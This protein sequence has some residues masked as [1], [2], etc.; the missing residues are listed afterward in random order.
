MFHHG[1]VQATVA[2]YSAKAENA[3]AIALLLTMAALPILEV[4]LRMAFGFGIPGVIAY[5]QNLALC[6][7]F[8]G[9][10][11]A[12]RHGRHLGLS[13]GLAGLRPP[14][15]KALVGSSAAITVA[16]TAGLF[17]ASVQFVSSEISSPE[18]IGGILPIWVVILVLPLSYGVVL[19]RTLTCGKEWRSWLAAFLGL[20]ICLAI[21]S[22]PD[23]LAALLTWPAIAVLIASVFIGA[24]IFVVLGGAALVLFMAE[25][26]PV[27][28]IP[29]ETYRI[30]TSPTIP[31]IP[32][33]T[34][35][36][37]LLAESRA[38][39][40]LVRLFRALFGWLP[41]GMAIVTTLICAFFA[42][43]TGTSGVTI[44]ALGG[45]LYPVLLE[46]GYRKRFSLGLLTSTGSIGLLFPPS[47]AIVLYG[48]VA[49]LPIPDLFLAGVVPGVL[50]VV[51][52]SLLAL[53]EGLRAERSRVRFDAME[54]CAAIWGAKWE[55]M[56]PL[57]VLVGIFGGFMTLVEAAALSAIYT[58]FVVT[59][60]YRDLDLYADLPRVF[61][62]CAML[63]GAVF[64]VL[65]VALGLTNYMVD[66]QIPVKAA[67]W[68]KH[69]IDSPLVFLLALNLFLLVV[70]C[71]LD[72]F[73]AIVVV[74]PLLI[75][76]GAAFGIHP[77]H[78]AVIFL[79]NLEL[80]FMTPPVGLNLFLASFRLEKPLVEVYRSTLPFL[81]A[82][83][84]VLIIVTYV[85]G[86]LLGVNADSGLIGAL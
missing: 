23:Q 21:A 69:H 72:V 77:L 40:R 53:R 13:I 74:V 76:M 52:V 15:R 38:S 7:G 8:V 63:V 37:Y 86:I 58:M 71:L 65:G 5:V 55:M 3:L 83:L 33:F 84:V 17:W 54:A 28:A 11:I 78:L 9:A 34:L 79:V 56:L 70:G 81:L 82:L 60:I 61:V 39:T 18:K 26:V 20:P 66:A 64:I 41:G 27:A 46:S 19:V 30:V 51:A 4:A 14:I 12:T 68:V 6:V 43:F 47:L 75:P 85:P 49:H 16:V 24:P 2:E 25:G 42:T 62:K 73:S 50:M 22:L 67:A 36:G 31:A 29:V 80:G 44:L 45:F 35:T 59:V 32:I 57:L 48:V 10:M 1:T